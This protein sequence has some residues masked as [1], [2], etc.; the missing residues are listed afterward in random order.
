MAIQLDR[1]AAFVMIWM[2]ACGDKSAQLD[3][4]RLQTSVDGS[5]AAAEADSGIYHQGSGY[6]CCGPGKGVMCCTADAGLL[7]YEIEPD[8]AIVA[9]GRERSG[10]TEANCFEYGGSAG[11]CAT[12]GQAFDAK[13]ICSLCCA[14]LSRVNPMAPDDAGTCSPSAP[15]SVF[16]CLPCGDGT[17]EPSENH[18]TCPNDRP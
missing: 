17:C 12:E 9:F 16:T 13:D 11:T 5:V 4:T 8:G 1:L 15:P 10:S 2:P 3:S 6:T 14:G 7:G 18:C